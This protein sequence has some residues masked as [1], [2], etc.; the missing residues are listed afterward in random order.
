[1]R[2]SRQDKKRWRRRDAVVA[3]R[4]RSL[5]LIRRQRPIRTSRPGRGLVPMPSIAPRVSIVAVFALVVFSVIL[6]RLWSLEIL[7]GNDY[8][9]RANDNR[10][11]SVTLPAPRGAILDRNGKILVDNRPGLAVG[12]RPMDVPAHELGRVLAGLSQILGVPAQKMQTDIVNEMRLMFDRTL[13]F[14]EIDAHQAAGGYDLVVVKRD[15]SEQVVSYLLEHQLSFP[16][17]E[18]RQDYLRDYPQGDLAAH[19]LGFVGP[20]SAPELTWT[21]FQGYYPG[22]VVG[23]S[24]VEATYDKWLRGRDGQAKIEVDA[25][26]RP[27]GG[28]QL[29]GGR[30]PQAGDNLVLSIENGVQ[31]A[32]QNALAYGI[33]LA[34]QS[35]SGRANGGAAVVLDAKS[36]EVIAMASDPTYDPRIWAGGITAKD[37]KKLAAAGANH[38]LIDKADAGLYPTGSTFKVVDSIAALESGAI[39]PATVLNAGGTYA[40]H[41]SVWHDWNPAGHGAIDLTQAIV[42]SADTYFYQVGYMFYLRKGTELEDW[43]TRLGYGRPTG[44]DMPGELAGLVP[45]PAWR[46]KT[47]SSAIDKLWKPG[48][49]IN[50]AIGQGDF[51]ATP[52]QVAVNYAAIANGGYLVTPHLGVK[53]T[54][55]DGS[56]VERLTSPPPRSL[57]IAAGTISVVRNALRLA[58]STPQG[59]SYPV[60]GNYP[61]PVA[62]KTG[63]A[64]VAGK[65]D[66]AW[67]ASFAPANDPK[68]VVVVMI[69]QG[70]HGGSAAAPAA[71]MIYDALFDTHTGKVS[72][73]IRSD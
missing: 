41:G 28:G 43:A 11:R 33:Q 34:H 16:G 35:G 42:Q 2:L 5:N 19:V 13:T 8:V 72:G 67:Y 37:F 21:Q 22:D 1:M 15:V 40:N 6:F 24:G 64:Q 73:A 30:A 50:L 61:I 51:L 65:G 62:G 36:G 60:F 32:A 52:L 47:Y 10:L 46:R 49:S 31:K 29:A 55:S 58:A 68:Y 45:T 71:R 38:P 70:G 17:V 4:S 59:T 57:G 3:G 25:L 12:I 9:A 56:L 54:A 23:Q 39:S 14:A 63:T 69:E 53:V 48:N 20:I 26:G 7:N 66:Y 18:V 44:I 27:R